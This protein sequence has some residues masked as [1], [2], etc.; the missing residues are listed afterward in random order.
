MKN[1]TTKVEESK[2]GEQE[3]KVDETISL[4]EFLK[5]GRWV[6]GIFYQISPFH[7]TVYL[8]AY[9]INSFLTIGTG[10]VLTRFVNKAIIL[11]QENN[12]DITLIYPYLGLFILIGFVQTLISLQIT[13]SRTNV[14]SRASFL[15]TQL[16]YKQVYSLGIQKLESPDITNKINRASSEIRALTEFYSETIKT[17]RY[18][19]NLVSYGVI[20]ATFAPIVIVVLFLVAIPQAI[21]DKKFRRLN[22]RLH[23]DNTENRRRSNTLAGDLSSPVELL[24]IYITNAYNYLDR[25]YQEFADYFIALRIN[26]IKREIKWDLFL[27]TLNDIAI[28]F[29]YLIAFQKFIAKVFDAGNLLF[30]ARTVS[31]FRSNLE[32]ITYSINRTVEQS[33]RLKEVYSL[34]N[35][36]PAVK[37]GHIKL[38]KFT[39]GPSI[40][41]KDLSFK[42]QKSKVNVLKNLNIEIFS[43]EKIAIVGHNGSGKTTLVKLICR[44]YKPTEGNILINNI[45]LADI[46]SESWYKNIGVLFQDYNIYTPLSVED[47]IHLGRPDEPLDEYKLAAAAD[48][49]DIL[50]FVSEYPNKFKQILSERYKGGIRPST[51]QWQKIAIARFFY[52]NAPLVIFDEPT[53]AID[54]VSEY[55]IFN[56]I[57]EFF[58]GKTVIIISHRFSTVRN[59]DR[60]IVMDHGKIIEDGSHLELME[61]NGY[62]AKSFRL[63]AEGYSDK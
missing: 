29:G 19:T 26:L 39:H 17:F 34:F 35:E 10:Y 1:N 4:R 33:I 45:D 49:A 8:S 36:T 22:W 51:G 2:E 61:M 30:Y 50:E 7:S 5:L 3:E 28:A 57:Y 9:I 18:I 11:V 42:Y 62:Y 55:K 63:Q 41:L 38:D 13:Y 24:E 60:I 12:Q 23:Y 53:A 6:L 56:K 25:R 20:I 46:Q 48:N 40:E 27:M 16:L 43:G 58:K 44:V 59:A 52:R 47:N 14:N 32:S 21:I 31:E 37:D 54:A 15:L